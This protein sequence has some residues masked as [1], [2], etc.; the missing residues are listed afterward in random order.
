MH[1]LSLLF[2]ALAVLQSS[3]AQCGGKGE[4][5]GSCDAN[6]PQICNFEGKVYNCGPKADCI[7]GCSVFVTGGAGFGDVVD[8]SQGEANL[9]TSSAL[10]SEKCC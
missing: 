2:T 7:N 1:A 6:D 8:V 10:T 5:P 9:A 3:Y 4:K